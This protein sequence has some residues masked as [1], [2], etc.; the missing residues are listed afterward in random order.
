MNTRNLSMI[1]CSLL[2]SA[3]AISAQ[4]TDNSQVINGHRFVDLGLPDGLLW[5]ETNIGA[6][7]PGDQGL[8]FAWGEIEGS[9][10]KSFDRNTYK[11][12]NKSAVAENDIDYTKYNSLDKKT[13]LDK[14]DD[15]AYVRWGAPCRMPTVF[16]FYELTDSDNCTWEWTDIPTSFGSIGGWKVTSVRNGNYIYL[17]AWGYVIFDDL[18]DEGGYGCYWSSNADDDGYY[19]YVL[20]FNDNLYGVDAPA[21]ERQIGCNIRPVAEP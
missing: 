4:V 17:P 10:M 20:D 15:A 18:K 14:E 11:F 1:L 6:D 16:D 19:V 9:D 3:Q 12:W 13:A 2:L 7:G 8:F 5:A 21:T